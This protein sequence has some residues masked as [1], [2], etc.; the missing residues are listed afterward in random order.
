MKSEYSVSRYL[1]GSPHD[2]VVHLPF[3]VHH[4]TDV[5]T[6]RRVRPSISALASLSL[7]RGPDWSD[8]P[9]VGE[10]AGDR[11]NMDVISKKGVRKAIFRPSATIVR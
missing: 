6:T 8:D 1:V 4:A 7:S 5:T 11:G 10:A 9:L 3:A 2:S